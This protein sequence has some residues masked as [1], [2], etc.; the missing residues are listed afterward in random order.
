MVSPHITWFS[1]FCEVIVFFSGA[2][3]IR[4]SLGSSPATSPSTTPKS[5]HQEWT[6]SSGARGFR[7]NQVTT[8]SH[9]RHHMV[10]RLIFSV[11]NERRLERV[12][13]TW[14]PID[15]V[16]LEFFPRISPRFQSSSHLVC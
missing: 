2:W 1:D 14:K 11:Y 3:L 12:D 8:S 16:N 4:V 7:Y 6:E 10:E 5:R 15:L 13:T 9:R